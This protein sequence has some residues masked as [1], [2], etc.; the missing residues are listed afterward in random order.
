MKEQ[1][2]VSKRLLG[3]TLS[4]ISSTPDIEECENCSLCLPDKE[5][6]ISSLGVMNFPRKAAKKPPR[7]ERTL[8]CVVT[9]K[10]NAGDAE[11]YFLVQRPNVGLLAGM[12][13]F[14]SILLE[15]EMTE[16]EQKCTV[17]DRL[18]ELLGSSVTEK[19][20]QYLGEVVHIFSH[21]HQT[22][23]VYSN[24]LGSAPID[25]VKQGETKC[26][27][28]RWVTKAEFQQSAVS[29]A[30]KK[31]LKLSS[32]SSTVEK[33]LDKDDKRVRGSEKNRKEQK[34]RKHKA[35]TE[36]GGRQL[37]MDSFFRTTVKESL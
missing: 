28:F 29:T 34:R 13:E 14:P 31:V 12:W 24:S 7:T 18:T 26:P 8:T 6:W 36:H 2:S 9:R 15:V 37:S 32:H 17:L 10:R 30:M 1:E 11:E 16:K 23:L 4:K 25:T 21:I 27:P 33:L 20:L 19:N 35:P 22:Y 5:S 3:N